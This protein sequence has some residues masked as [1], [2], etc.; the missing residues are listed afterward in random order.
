MYL[1][2]KYDINP[3]KIREWYHDIAYQNSDIDLFIYGLDEEAAKQKILE[4]YET[5]NNVVPCDVACFRKVLTGF[6][7]DCCSVGFDGK[8][9]WA[10]PRA[11]QAIIKQ[12]KYG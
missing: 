5:V 1:Q 10:L 12:C 4:I 3:R 8:N 9:V 2:Q 6:D 11:H 7:V